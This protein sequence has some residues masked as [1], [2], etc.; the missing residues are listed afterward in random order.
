MVYDVYPVPKLTR[1]LIYT[2]VYL[3]ANR[4]SL[5]NYYSWEGILFLI[6]KLQ[7]VDQ[8]TFT[9]GG[10][11]SLLRLNGLVLVRLDV[12]YQL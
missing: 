4:N 8:T 1:Y 9:F 6:L 11:D 10:L 2:L 7:F 3:T 5:K 12:R